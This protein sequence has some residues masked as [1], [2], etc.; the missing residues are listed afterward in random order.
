MIQ[1][2][3]RT[4]TTPECPKSTIR[5]F[6][7]V[8]FFKE[9]LFQF[10]SFFMLLYVQ[11]ASP[12]AQNVRFTDMFFLISMVLI[13]SKILAGFC[14]S[15]SS[16]ALETGKFR[17]GRF[18]TMTFIG[19][20]L[21]TLFS[22]LTFFVAPLCGNGWAYVISFLIFYTCSECVFSIN[23]IAYWSYVNKMTYDE[24]KRSKIMGITNLSASL[25]SYLVAALSPAISAGNA[26]R[27][28]STLLIVLLSCFFLVHIIYCIFMFERADDATFDFKHNGKLFESIRI[29]SHDKQVFLVILCY[30]LF[31]IAQDLIAGNTTS[32]FYYEYGY[33]GFGANGID[34]GLSG[35]TVSFGFLLCFGLSVSL[36]SFVY[37]YFAKPLGKK[38]TMVL[39][40]TLLVVLY[41]LLFFFGMKR[42]NE[43]SLFIL[44][45][46]L[47]FSH[48]LVL[49][50][51]NMNVIDVAEYYQAKT[52]KERS[53]SIQAA[54]A[55]AVKTANGIQTGIFYLFL[56]ISPNLIDVNREVAALEAMNNR[57]E[58]EGSVI[59]SV[60]SYV[61]SFSDI[62]HSLSIYRGSLT[63]LPI[64]ICVI[65]VSL[66][67]FVYVSDERKYEEYVEKVQSDQTNI[68]NQ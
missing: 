38:K 33:G 2:K 47:G 54:K 63:L 25:G 12:I 41:L 4:F 8:S 59:D 3:N 39:G 58:L 31:F 27:N 52:G 43:I 9:A 61:H 68:K 24:G 40:S 14:W 35:G 6:E 26:K 18:R 56:A 30:F 19:A 57:G 10:N 32:Y 64:V 36:A 29:L 17:Y 48:G 28:M 13:G 50:A 53:A 5:L 1:I 45:A 20:S 15:L 23:D 51:L 60:N 55:L 7:F 49:M 11:L 44:T 67:F 65:A 46:L 34:G 22:F 66:A 37:P 62:E 42:G 21:S 16:H